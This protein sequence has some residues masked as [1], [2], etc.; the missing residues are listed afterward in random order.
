ML[1]IQAQLLLQTQAAHS[2]RIS[3]GRTTSLTILQ[4]QASLMSVFYLVQTFKHHNPIQVAYTTPN[5]SETP[6]VCAAPKKRRQK[7]SLM[8][9][10]DL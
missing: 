5:C 2:L 7:D 8:G 1:W 3:R 4:K 9:F 10:F 6:V